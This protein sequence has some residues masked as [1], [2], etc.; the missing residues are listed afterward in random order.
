MVS[1]CQALCIACWQNHEEGAVETQLVL[2]QIRERERERIWEEE[3][4]SSFFFHVCC[5]WKFK[6]GGKEN[7][8]LGTQE[9]SR[10]KKWWEDR[11]RAGHKS[12][13]Y[14]QSWVSAA[15][16]NLTDDWISKFLFLP[17]LCKWF[18]LGWDPRRVWEKKQSKSREMIIWWNKHG[19]V[20]KAA[21]P[22]AAPGKRP[23][24]EPFSWF[25]Y[26]SGY[27]PVKSLSINNMSNY[28]TAEGYPS[29][30]HHTKGLLA[31]FMGFN[32]M[33]GEQGQHEQVE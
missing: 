24:N 11:R 32:P 4:I 30:K 25:S 28:W 2:K 29:H 15:V 5:I 20:L 8:D 1:T 13:L 27:N 18:W 33:L 31:I 21:W 10:W 7:R 14:L 9:I 19:H 3:I 6:G 26:H 23:S 16:R 17:A 12:S 22:P